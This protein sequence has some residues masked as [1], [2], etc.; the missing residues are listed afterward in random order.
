MRQ[1]APILDFATAIGF[2]LLG[3]SVQHPALATETSDPRKFVY[4]GQISGVDASAQTFTAKYGD[5]EFV[6]VVPK[7]AIIAKQGKKADFGA[8]TVGA[9]ATACLAQ[10]SDGKQA[11]QE[12][13]ISPR[14]GKRYEFSAEVIEVNRDA[15]T[16]TCRKRDGT[17]RVV[18]LVDETV[19]ANGAAPAE[20]SA[21][22]AGVYAGFT[23]ATLEGD[24]CEADSV[25]ILR[26]DTKSANKSAPTNDDGE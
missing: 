26:R 11:A 19:F 17:N 20:F 3:S 21:I 24:K 5:K 22:K 6:I 14:P 8:I 9:F 7:K 2:L 25:T 4:L 16:I 12:V 18:N 10:I 1:H 23:C 15:K 13:R